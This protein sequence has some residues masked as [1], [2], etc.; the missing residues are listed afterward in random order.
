MV[1][2]EGQAQPD[3]CSRLGNSLH[4]FGFTILVPGFDDDDED[5]DDDGPGFA[6]TLYMDQVL[7]MTQLG[8]CKSSMLPTESREAF[9]PGPLS[10]VGPARPSAAWVCVEASL[11]QAGV[12]PLA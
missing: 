11:F 4:G 12:L 10:I 1:A 3:W 9:W 5:D 8:I 7:M 2:S 6:T